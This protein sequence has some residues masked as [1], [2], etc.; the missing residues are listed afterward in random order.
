MITLFHWDTPNAL[1]E[2]YG[3]WNSR[4]IVEPFTKFAETV[5]ERYSDKVKFW[6]TFNEPYSF[7][8][9]GHDIGVMAPGKRAEGYNCAHHQLLAHA[10]VYHMYDQTYRTRSP[11]GEGKISLTCIAEYAEPQGLFSM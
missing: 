3:G 7:C 9:N 5:F 4:E 2:Q 1:Q 8:V 10:E 6:F 11:G